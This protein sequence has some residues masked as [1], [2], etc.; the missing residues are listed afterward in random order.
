MFT[1]LPLP[2]SLNSTYDVTGHPPRIEG[3]DQ[4]TVKFVRFIAMTFGI[5]IFIGGMQA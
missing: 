1:S 4:V 2:S 5:S 3:G